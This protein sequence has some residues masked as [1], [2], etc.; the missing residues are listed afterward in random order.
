MGRRLNQIVDL[1]KEAFVRWQRDKAPMLAGAL[2]FYMIFSLAPLLLIAAAVAG[3]VFEE[4]GVQTLIVDRAEKILGA[5]AAQVI[6]DI[7]ADASGRPGNPVAMIISTGVLFFGAAAVFN[8]LQVVLDTIWGAARPARDPLSGIFALVRQYL[9]SFAMALGIGFLVLLA[10][11]LATLV[12]SM[13]TTLEGQW[14]VLDDLLRVAQPLLTLVILPLFCGIVF[15]TLP[16][17]DIHLRDVWLGALITALLLALGT[18]V[19]SVYLGLVG[20]GSAYG[21]AS[22]LVA[23][24][25][26]IYYSAQIFLF[27]AEFTVIYANRYG[28]LAQSAQDAGSPAT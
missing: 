14:P 13:R 27:G 12:S 23:M 26:W 10:L 22:S 17:V 15:I 5:E 3:M 21:A 6:E 18:Y 11:V 20:T 24:L 19:F 4:A 28:S 25:L 9:W 16:R 1:F 8:Q 2:A 7:Y